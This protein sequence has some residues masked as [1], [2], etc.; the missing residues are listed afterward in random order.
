MNPPPLLPAPNSC[1]HFWQG[2]AKILAESDLSCSKYFR[3]H[4]LSHHAL[5]Y[6]VRKQTAGTRPKPLLVLVEVR[7]SLRGPR[8]SR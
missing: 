8:H 3:R 2:H 6:W 4:N 5:T 1:E 7:S